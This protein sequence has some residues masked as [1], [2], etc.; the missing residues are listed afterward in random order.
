MFRFPV[1]PAAI[2]IGVGIEVAWNA[3]VASWRKW[4]PA[5]AALGIVQ[6]LPTLVVGNIGTWYQVDRYTNKI[7]WNPA[8]QEKVGALTLSLLVIMI[9]SAIAGWVITGTAISGLRGRPMTAGWVVSRGL[10]SIVAGIVLA[11]GFI[12]V[13]FAGLIVVAVLAR[14]AG[15]MALLAIAGVV[16]LVYVV[17][18]LI[19]FTVAIFDGFGALDSFSESWQ[20]S[21]QSVWRLFGWALM[22]GLIGLGFSILSA[23]AAGVAGSLKVSGVAEMASGVVSGTSTVLVLFLLTVLYESQRARR[24]YI[25]RAAYATPGPMPYPGAPYAG[26]P[27]PQQ[28][29]AQPQAPQ[30]WPAQPQAPQQWPEQPQAPQQWPEQ[31]QAPQQWPEQ[32]QTP[33]PVDPDGGTGA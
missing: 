12:V 7:I 19:F 25:R 23:I 9:V 2:T 28:W 13:G 16:A 22:A 10:V 21:D 17:I 6:A 15:I 27:Y 8:L 29:P 31:P 11:V 33:P 26:M 24:E 18:R 14:L 4:L 20:L 30:Q 32:P 1:D 5:V 3:M